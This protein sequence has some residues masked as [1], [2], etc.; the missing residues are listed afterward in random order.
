MSAADPRMGQ[1]RR[2]VSFMV[3]EG[4]EVK[5]KPRLFAAGGDAS[6]SFREPAAGCPSK[7]VTF[8][9]HSFARR[10][11]AAVLGNP[12]LLARCDAPGLIFVHVIVPRF[13]LY[14]SASR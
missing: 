12:G 11:L 9:L 8:L 5:S 1:R 10:L 7:S 2:E 6:G 14:D 4:C 3:W 13:L